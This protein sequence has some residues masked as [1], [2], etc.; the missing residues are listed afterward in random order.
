MARVYQ[1]NNTMVHFQSGAWSSAGVQ[2][3]K[4]GNQQNTTSVV[5]ATAT[6][7]E[8]LHCTQRRP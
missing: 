6:A 8:Q 4:H 1:W 7:A 3:A 5:P 2:P